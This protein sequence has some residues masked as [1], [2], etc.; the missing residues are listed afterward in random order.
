MSVGRA[1]GFVILAFGF[2]AALSLASAGAAKAQVILQPDSLQ[3]GATTPKVLNDQIREAAKTPRSA[4]SL[5][6]L[7]C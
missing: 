3:S 2:A 7:P 5:P 4:M 6:A 1:A